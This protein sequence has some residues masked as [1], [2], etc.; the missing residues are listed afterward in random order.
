MNPILRID[1]R[2]SG[3]PKNFTGCSHQ[4]GIKCW[5]FDPPCAEGD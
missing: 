2:S 5:Q 3:Q 4:T 1:S